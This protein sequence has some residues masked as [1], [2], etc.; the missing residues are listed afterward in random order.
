MYVLNINNMVI[1]VG[2][3]VPQITGQV[4]IGYG[5]QGSV[6]AGAFYRGS[7][8]CNMHAGNGTNNSYASLFAASRSSSLYKTNASV[9]PVSRKATFLIRY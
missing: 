4:T 1:S 6:Y 7:N 8:R 3:S 9:V 2:A 5:S